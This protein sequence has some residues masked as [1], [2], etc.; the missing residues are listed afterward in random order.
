MKSAKEKTIEFFKKK[1]GL[2]R[3]TEAL[4]H[5]IHR[6]TLYG[7]RD[8]GVLVA[9]SRGLYQLAEM[10]M[11]AEVSLAEVSK[12]GAER[13]NMSNGFCLLL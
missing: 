2:V 8:E 3:T 11:P 1:G 5:G 6:R 12:K 4:A 10:E 7:L 13:G 9:V